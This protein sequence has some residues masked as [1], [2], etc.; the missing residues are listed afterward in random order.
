VRCLGKHRCRRRHLPILNP[1]TSQNVNRSRRWYFRFS[2]LAHLFGAELQV[3]EVTTGLSCSVRF[4]SACHFGGWPCGFAPL[5]IV[6]RDP[7]KKRGYKRWQAANNYTADA[8][9][10]DY[11]D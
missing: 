4:R 10:Y 8:I 5:S 3:D 2:F 7:A 9:V 1:R 11:A 6:L